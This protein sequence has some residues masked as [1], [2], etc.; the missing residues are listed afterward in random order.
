MKP[1]VAW[2]LVAGCG[3]H[4]GSFTDRQ[5]TSPG[6]HTT[7]GCIDLA[8][9]RADDSEAGPLIDYF[10]GNRCDHRVTVDLAHVRVIARSD[11][12]ADVSLAAYD[13]RNELIPRL[14]NAQWSGRARIEYRAAEPVAS[15]CVDVGGIEH[16]RA[17]EQWV[18]MAHVRSAP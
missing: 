1:L 8:V 15:V 9:S 12:G 10:V 2:S 14:L 11:T 6:A 16:A 7:L 17:P 4:P 13:P 18:C 5:G 3:Y